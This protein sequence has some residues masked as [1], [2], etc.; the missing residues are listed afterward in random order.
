MRGLVQLD[1]GAV[2]AA[3]CRARV[4]QI[5]QR[6]GP[7]LYSQALLI[8]GAK[9]LAERVAGDV[10]AAESTRLVVPQEGEQAATHRL[11]VSVLRR[12]RELAPGPNPADSQLPLRRERE[13]L[14]LVLFGGLGY[15]QV[16]RELAIPAREAAVLLRTAL[17]SLDVSAVPS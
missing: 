6:Y 10:I 16:G 5:Y 4:P 13:A 9:D 3:A 1:Q 2:T 12:C 15:R 17:M 11:A 14:S 8:L 7:A